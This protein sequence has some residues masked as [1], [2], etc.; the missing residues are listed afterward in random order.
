METPIRQN[1]RDNS[2]N[3]TNYQVKWTAENCLKMG[4]INQ[5]YDMLL[6]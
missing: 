3:D 2:V 4:Q 5:L 6:N 1:T